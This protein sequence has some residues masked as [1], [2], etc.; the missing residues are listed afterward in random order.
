MEG[1]LVMDDMTAEA[2]PDYL[3]MSASI[4]KSA[5]EPVANAHADLKKDI[6]DISVKVTLNVEVGGEFKEIYKAKDFYPCKDEV[7]DVRKTRNKG[8]SKPK[9]LSISTFPRQDFLK[10]ALD[11][12]EKYGNLKIECPMKAVIIQCLE[13]E[14][15]FQFMSV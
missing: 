10:Y 9:T 4:D 5:P 15:L 12:I 3:T 8:F 11:Q 13:T 2:N 7:E 1:K 6:D 14:K